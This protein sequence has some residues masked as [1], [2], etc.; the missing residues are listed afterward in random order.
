MPRLPESGI[1]AM[2]KFNLGSGR[3]RTKMVCIASE[4]SG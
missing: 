4:E 2:D 1:P 3:V